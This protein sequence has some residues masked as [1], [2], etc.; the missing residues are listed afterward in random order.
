MA[1]DTTPM[2]QARREDFWHTVGWRPDLPEDQR[3]AIEQAWP[4]P[5]IEEAESHGF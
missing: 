5:M 1:E 3:L 2:S 4:D